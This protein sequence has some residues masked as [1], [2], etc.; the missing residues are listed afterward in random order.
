MD[1]VASLYQ[2]QQFIEIINSFA[3][4]VFI[5]IIVGGVIRSLED[6]ETMLRN[7]SD[8]LGINTASVRNPDLITQGAEA[9]GTQCMVLSIEA[10]KVA[11]GKWECYTDNGREQSGLDAV[12]WAVRGEELG[13]GETLVTSVDN[14]GTRSGFDAELIRSVRRAVS[15][16]VIASGGAGKPDDIVRLYGDADPSAACVATMLH[17][18]VTDI[19]AL[20]NALADAGVKVRR[21]QRDMP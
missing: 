13:A 14:D 11:P 16:P 12:Q 4:E 5:P 18:G 2:R 6:M 8:K 15:V 3:A 21:P 20:K 1:T 19:A 10:K 7:L 17:Y 9:F